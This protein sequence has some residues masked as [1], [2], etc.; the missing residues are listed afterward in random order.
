MSRRHGPIRRNQ[1]SATQVMSISERIGD[2]I[3]PLQQKY[4]VSNP[5][6]F[7]VIYFFNCA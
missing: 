4:T 3:C 1:G 2:V 7:S 5:I 6:S